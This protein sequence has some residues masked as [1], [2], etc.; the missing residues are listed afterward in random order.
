M[1]GDTPTRYS[2]VEFRSATL[3][4]ALC[5]G[6]GGRESEAGSE[7]WTFVKFVLEFPVNVELAVVLVGKAVVFTVISGV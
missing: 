2:A 1:T 6:L 3:P 4:K 7:L 5:N